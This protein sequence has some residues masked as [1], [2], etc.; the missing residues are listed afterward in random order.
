MAR[1]ESPKPTWEDSGA[2][3]SVE[4]DHMTKVMASGRPTNNKET[5]GRNDRGFSLFVKLRHG[6]DDDGYRANPVGPEQSN[7]E[8]VP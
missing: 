7:G 3:R 2:S 5:P 6:P 1:P 8:A 4:P